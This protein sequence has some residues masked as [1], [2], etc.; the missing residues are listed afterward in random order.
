MGTSIVTGTGRFVVEKTGNSTALSAMAGQLTARRAATPP[1]RGTQQF[2][3]MILRL[4]L[5]LVLFVLLV[6]AA[7]HRAWLDSFL[8]AVALA[9]GLTP[10]LLP[11]IVSVTLARGALR[12]AK[13]HLIVK[14]PS[15]IY[16]LGG[17]DVL[18]TDKTGTLTEATIRVAGFENAQGER[19]KAPTLV[20]K[21]APE[22]VLCRCT[23][24]VGTSGEGERA[25]DDALAQALL[26][27]FEGHG[28]QGLRVLAIARRTLPEDRTRITADDEQNLTFA[29]T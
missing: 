7:F 19:D 22:D 27:R 18:C 3:M 4:T 8:F 10:E 12:L 6:N 14:R 16:A 25:L 26:A 23:H 24:Y 20:V 15:A 17:M 2:G 29:V 28:E 21:G 5:F 9:V 11:M 13:R 1:E